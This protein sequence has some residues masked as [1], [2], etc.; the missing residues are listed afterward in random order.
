MPLTQ[1]QHQTSARLRPALVL[2]VLILA[3]ITILISWALAAPPGASPDD[4]YHLASIWCADGFKDDRCLPDPVRPERT[5]ALVP[6]SVLD[7]ACFQYD[8]SRSAAC[9]VDRPS[10]SMMQ[11][12][13]M[14]TNLGG[15]RPNLYYRS[16][17]L[18][19]TD[20]IDAS[21]AR[22]RTANVALA[23]LMI[24]GT[25]I[26]ADRRLRAA[27]LLTM[28]STSV[29]LWLFLVT[30][31]NSSAWG[32]IG[33][34][35]LWANGLTALS[36]SKR[37]NRAVGAVLAVLGTILSLGSRT[38]AVVHLAVTMS[39]LAILWWGV[40]RAAP[41]PRE[42]S[43][44]TVPQRLLAGATL[45]LIGYAIIAAVPDSAALDRAVRDLVSGY[46]RI[47]D[48]QVG[49]PLLALAFDVP[50]LWVGALGHMWGLGAL[51]TPVPVLSAFAVMGSF[52]ALLALGLQ[53]AQKLRIA[54]AGVVGAAL[55]VFPSF[56]LLRSGLL[57][58]EQLQPRQ[59]MAL[60]FVLL[61]TALYRLPGEPDLVLGRGMRTT[62]VAALTLGNS[63]ALLVTIRRHVSGLLR[64]ALGEY[65]HVDFTSDIEWWWTTAPHPNTVWAIGSIAYLVAAIMVF[66]MFAGPSED[67]KS[68]Q[69]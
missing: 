30:S 65:R 36:N 24:V 25:A 55:L 26:V 47:A 53:N 3:L 56:A 10:L 5:R 6:Q 38:E 69:R 59:F 7:V 57:V 45:L 62:L 52:V 31:V 64:G 33:L 49:N 32:L 39:V 20:D 63:I 61:G 43:I 54:A 58:F 12:V 18:L 9:A 44:R 40:R 13:P 2:S 28:L 51:D 8:G 14:E 67:P 68:A 23:V 21:I 41:L 34:T 22:M 1:P 11:F 50:S 15:Q 46:G 29:P 66:R 17:H 60:L 16:M 37:T 19:I 35:T 4:G 48:K 27:F 42:K